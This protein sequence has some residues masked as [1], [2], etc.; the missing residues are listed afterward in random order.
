M[1]SHPGNVSERP[2]S[3]RA[4]N[5]AQSQPKLLPAFEP[6]SSSPALPRP[7]K[8]SFDTSHDVDRPSLNH[9]PS[10]MPTSDTAPIP[11]SS[12]APFPKTRPNFQRTVSTLSE[13]QPL[14]ALPTIDLPE[15]GSE[16]LM[17]RSSYSSHH[18][19][20]ANRTISRVHVRAKYVPP[21]DTRPEHVF[22]RCQGW[23]GC[24][25]IC[26]G[27]IHELRKDD[28]FSVEGAKTEIILDVQDTR[29]MLRWPG[30]QRQDSPAAGSD[31]TWDDGG[32][33]IR[34]RPFTPP[35]DLPSS[36]PQARVH[37]QSPVSPSPQNLPQPTA[38]STFIGMSGGSPSRPSVEIYED[39]F[40]DEDDEPAVRDCATP[41]P[42][43]VEKASASRTSEPESSPLSEVEEFSDPDE[44]NDP[45][46]HSFGIFGDSLLPRMASIS[47]VSPQRRRR[48]L[49]ASVSP[50][51][52]SASQLSHDIDL[53]P[54]RNHVINQLAYST[55]QSLP[56][57]TIMNSLPVEMKT[58]SNGVASPSEA[59]NKPTTPAKPN[60]ADSDLKKLLD[61][62]ACIGEIE[63]EG[64]DAAGKPLENEYYYVGEMDADEGRRNA[65]EHSLGKTGLRSVRKQHKVI[66]LVEQDRL[67][68]PRGCRR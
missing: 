41:K 9:Y 16:V 21:T 33:P 24:K 32:S 42:E 44:E 58:S 36:P 4:S 13:R 53:D 20:S 6:T 18:Q 59:E 28:T 30:M 37:L 63:R 47:A 61:E 12:S 43:P 26:K 45:M 11:S 5:G 17:G 65:V 7:V 57:S 62:T 19:L 14:G 52:L 55:R 49:R 40:G 48:P 46:I 27:N 10:P 67:D 8:R 29:A 31:A 2:S 34:R 54:I 66:S 15:V 3:T 38:S 23:N 56:L 1:E 22:I 68:G 39:A 35:E 64:K 50:Q 51:Q 60:F 25:V